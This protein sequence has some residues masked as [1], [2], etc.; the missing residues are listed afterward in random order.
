V[1][2]SVGREGPIVQIGSAFASTLG[3]LVRMSE[4]RLRIGVARGAARGIAAPFNPP[5]TRP[6]FRFQIVLREF[7]PHALVAPILAAV[8]GALVSQAFFG[9]APFFAAIPHGL[10]IT[11]DYAYLLVAV[12]GVASGLIGIGFKTVLYKL[13]DIVEELWKGRP[14]W[15][16]PAFG[17]VA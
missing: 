17:G 16:L 3:Q 8:T 10:T 9:S 14:E 7:S 6:V 4:N 1:G 15:A 5:I 13:E 12:L 11:N 2:G